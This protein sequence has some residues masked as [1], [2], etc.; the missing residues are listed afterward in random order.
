LLDLGAD[1]K[2][3]SSEWCDKTALEEAAGNNNV[4]LVHLLIA[5]GADPNALGAADDASSAAN[6][7]D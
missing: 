7:D 2:F 5:K 6:D 3:R 1:V 4:D